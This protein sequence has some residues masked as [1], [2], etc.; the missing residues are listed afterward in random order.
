MLPRILG[1]PRYGLD[2][3]ELSPDKREQ[4]LSRDLNQLA[5][6]SS[7]AQLSLLILLLQA[8]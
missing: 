2:P 8:L 3:A 7:V 5:L 4:L 1:K 6:L